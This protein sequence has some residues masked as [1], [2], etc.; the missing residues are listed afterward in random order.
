MR[1]EKHDAL[2]LRAR[3]IDERLAF[4][5]PNPAQYR[6]ARAKPD[7]RKLHHRLACGGDRRVP[8]RDLPIAGERQVLAQQAAVARRHEIDEPAERRAHCVQHGQGENRD[9]AHQQTQH[10]GRA[11]GRV[12]NLWYPCALLA[13]A[14]RPFGSACHSHEAH[15]Q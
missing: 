11:W 4:D 7:R 9:R 2:A 15:T 10:A 5:A 6:G 3:G 14:G 13:T 8:H 1:R 12:S